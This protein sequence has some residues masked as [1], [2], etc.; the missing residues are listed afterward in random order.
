M[1][2]QTNGEIVA[3]QLV[4]AGLET[5][6]FLFTLTVKLTWVSNS[7]SVFHLAVTHQGKI[8]LG[9]TYHI[10]MLI[11]DSCVTFNVN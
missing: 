6:L 11:V 9:N 10:L 3:H 7:S 8:T 1:K 2:S 5:C 4:L